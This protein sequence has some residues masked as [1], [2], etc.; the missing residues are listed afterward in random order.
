[1]KTYVNTI[2]GKDYLY[3]YDRIFIDHGKTFQKTKS[4]GR[5]DTATDLA[6]KQHKFAIFIEKEEVIRRTRHWER[7]I[8]DPKFTKYVSVQKIEEKRAALFRAKE[9]MGEIATSAMETAFL[10]DFIYNSNKL[11]G[12]KIPRKSIEE[13]VLRQSKRGNEEI[14]NTLRALYFV[15][16]QFRFNAKRIRM[17][18]EIL[19]S[20][21]PGKLGFRTEKV[22]VG[23][24]DVCPWEKV[25]EKLHN[26][27]AWYEKAKKYMYPPELAF[28]FYYQFER[29]HPFKD[30]N[31]RTGRLIMNRI[32]K[33]HRYHPII[34]WN[35]KRNSHLSA[36]KKY[37]EERSHY[38][39][40]FMYSQFAKTHEVYLEKID[41]AFNL[42]ELSEYFLKPSEYNKS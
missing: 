33:D 22:V 8:T 2:K 40:K 11:E 25:K 6:D 3:A 17:L 12:S 41:K 28:D 4:L 42:E 29:I 23:E 9:R 16:N 38:F 18:H 27:C 13:I 7:K 14:D 1:M 20:H 21:E 15:D 39:Y 24:S 32:L 26:L 5:V 30:G 34:I 10:V 36:F 19:L 37:I 35:K 31:G